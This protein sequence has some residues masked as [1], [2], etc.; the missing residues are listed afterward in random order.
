MF[1]LLAAA[2][3]AVPPA[4]PT[5]VCHL[6][7]RP[8]AAVAATLTTRHSCCAVAVTDGRD[9]ARYALT[10]PGCCDLR[11]AAHPKMSASAPPDRPDFP[12][13]SVLVS[14]SAV[15]YP[16]ATETVVNAVADRRQDAPRGPPPRA[17]SPRAP[18]ALS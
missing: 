4:V 17:V 15:S 10:S 2:V 5:L 16:P 7:G 6:T 12:V 13:V 8:M 1:C 18:P 14:R 9:G 11:Y 3:F